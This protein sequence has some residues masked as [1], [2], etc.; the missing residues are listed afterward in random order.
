M[1]T[2]LL[3]RSTNLTVRELSDNQIPKQGTIYI[4]PPN[5]DAILSDGAIRLFAPENAVG[6]KPSV[7]RLFFSLAKEM[8]SKAVGVIL[9]G[10]GRDGAN[11]LREIKNARGIA[12][13]QD[14]ISS[15]YS[16]M[17]NAALQDSR[18]DYIVAPEKIGEVLDAFVAGRLYEPLPVD[19]ASYEL[20][21]VIQAIFEQTGMDLSGY[22][23]STLNRRLQ[24]RLQVLKCFDITTYA[25]VLKSDKEEAERFAREVLIS[26]TEFFRDDLPFTIL[27]NVFQEM[28]ANIEPGREIRIWNPGCA[29]GEETYSLAIIVEEIIRK[30]DKPI[31]YKIFATDIDLKALSIG[32]QGIYH[33]ES[34]KVFDEIWRQRYFDAEGDFLT[35]T[36]NIRN[37]IVFSEHNLAQDPPFSRIDLVS[38]RNLL[39]YFNNEL[40]KRVLSTFNYALSPNGILFLGQSE[41]IELHKDL[42]FPINREARI[43]RKQP[44]FTLP[45]PIKSGLQRHV[46]GDERRALLV[47]PVTKTLEQNVQQFI[48]EKYSPPGLVI[49]QM[50]EV[51][52]ITGNTDPFVTVRPGLSNNNIF[53]KSKDEFRS[54][55]R[56]LIHKCRRDKVVSEGSNRH[57]TN[58]PANCS[59]QMVAQL[60]TLKK[61]PEPGELVILSFVISSLEKQRSNR[62]KKTLEA[63]METQ[64]RVEELESELTSAEEHLR[65]CDRGAGNSK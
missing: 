60:L 22:K 49:N 37:N 17:P 34:C 26:V 35:A 12:I 55:A 39:I 42:F 28:L 63:D 8:G 9:S 13:V 53:N 5:T 30:L 45:H 52:H 2:E 21:G 43:F 41:S 14:P 11:G 4:I 64:Q 47:K 7:D 1:L 56:A 24:R 10:T 51:L 33:K 29:T 65:K 48:A 32:R 61:D 59:V 27:S 31:H 19:D 25:A 46:A 18:I 58:L 6:P 16:G 62:K 20:H 54:E 50:D 40:Q 44:N 36:K 3:A 57:L 15:K 23:T 38:C